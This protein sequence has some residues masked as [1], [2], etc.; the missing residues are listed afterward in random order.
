MEIKR[1]TACLRQNQS[2]IFLENRN[3]IRYRQARLLL[4][5]LEALLVSLLYNN[6]AILL[7]KKGID[8]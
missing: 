8:M 3:S 4:S 1:V 2:L 5:D 6:M 7:N